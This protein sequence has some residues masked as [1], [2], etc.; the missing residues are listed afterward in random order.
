[1]SVDVVTFAQ[2][3]K[4]ETL[5]TACC[6]SFLAGGGGVYFPSI[7]LVYSTIATLEKQHV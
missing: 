5:V 6:T 4:I 7:N 1:V 2:E 3:K